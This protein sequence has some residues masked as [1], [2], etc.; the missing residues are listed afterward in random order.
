MPAE[1]SRTR[2][3][4][5][6]SGKLCRWNWTDCNN[7]RLVNWFCSPGGWGGPSVRLPCYI[8]A[9]HL[10]GLPIP[11]IS[12]SLQV[13]SHEF[14]HA[15]NM[16]LVSRCWVAMFQPGPIRICRARGECFQL[17]HENENT[18]IEPKLQVFW[19]SI[20]QPWYLWVGTL[21][22]RPMQPQTPPTNILLHH[23]KEVC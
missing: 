5:E 23:F 15:G 18:R 12:I 4:T 1:H 21:V 22:S 7:P 11:T 8:A 6:V 16:P 14:K 13:H 17:Q 20:V 9:K 10:L 19:E 2:P 3:S